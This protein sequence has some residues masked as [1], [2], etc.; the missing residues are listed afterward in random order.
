MSGFHKLEG[1][2]NLIS[3][4]LDEFKYYLVFL[5]FA[6]CTR[7]D[8]IYSCLDCEWSGKGS[9]INPVMF[10][11]CSSMRQNW[12]DVRL[13][14]AMASGVW[15]RVRLPRCQWTK[16]FLIQCLDFAHCYSTWTNLST[17]SRHIRKWEEQLQLRNRNLRLIRIPVF[18]HQSNRLAK[19]WLAW[20]RIIYPPSQGVRCPGFRYSRRMS[21]YGLFL[22]TITNVNT[23]SRILLTYFLPAWKARLDLSYSGNIILLV[24]HNLLHACQNQI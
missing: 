16:I 23:S 14:H 17:N 9:D 21:I 18:R 15:A 6:D 8:M 10:I 20:K 3:F 13:E 11:L 2:N 1:E 24:T 22:P 19:F 7:S 5:I 4:Q 12:L